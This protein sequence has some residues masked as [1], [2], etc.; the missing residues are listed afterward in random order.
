ME[1]GGAE[2]SPDEMLSMREGYLPAGCMASVSKHRSSDGDKPWCLAP[3]HYACQ[4]PAA[5]RIRI[6]P[7]PVLPDLRRL[8]RRMPMHHHRPRRL[9]QHLALPSEEHLPNP[10]QVVRP[11][12][13]E[14]NARADPGMHEQIR[15]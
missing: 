8:H 3:E 14:R 10:D 11:L 7:D 2:A 1:A 4:G 6:Y 12:L 9:G 13:R 5:P 15:P